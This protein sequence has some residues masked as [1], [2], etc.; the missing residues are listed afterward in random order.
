MWDLQTLFSRTLNFPRLFKKYLCFKAVIYIPF[1]QTLKVTITQLFWVNK[2]S[3]SYLFI[4]RHIFVQTDWKEQLTVHL[5]R[6]L[7]YLMNWQPSLITC[8]TMTPCKSSIQGV[9]QFISV[10]CFCT[11]HTD[12]KTHMFPSFDLVVVLDCAS[13]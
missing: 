4:S 13:I 2:L 1:P 12:N 3:Y 11:R 6:F 5:Y 10:P 7:F 9:A 8:L